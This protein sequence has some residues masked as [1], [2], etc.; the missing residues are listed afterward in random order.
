ME[1]K[2][3]EFRIAFVSLKEGK[4][5]FDFKLDRSF[6]DAFE[7]EEFAE[8]D[9]L[10]KTELEIQST[11]MTL[12]FNISGTVNVMCDRCADYMDLPIEG[13]YRLIFKQS[14]DE[15]ND[16]DDIVSLAPSDHELDLSKHIYEFVL[17]SVPLKKVHEEGQCNADVLK[18][19]EE[20]KKDDKPDPR[21]DKLKN[22]K[23]DNDKD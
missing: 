10:V 5:Q 18:R 9:I 1:E 4:H 19:L 16:S 2:S 13:E 14:V 21:W 17:L 15:Y 12:N 3:G 6:F 8:C 23:F 22:I 20:E 11:F 7:Y